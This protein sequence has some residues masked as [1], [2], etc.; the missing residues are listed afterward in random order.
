MDRTYPM[1]LDI[2]DYGKIYLPGFV[3]AEVVLFFLLAVPMMVME[4]IALCQ[5]SKVTPERLTRTS[6]T[7]RAMPPTSACTNTV[8]IAPVPI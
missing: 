1:G 5:L 4:S 6:L 2:W 3:L 8:S 7:L